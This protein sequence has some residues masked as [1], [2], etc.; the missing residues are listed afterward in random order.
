MFYLL[1][2]HFIH[3][4]MFTGNKWR[5]SSLLCLLAVGGPIPSTEDTLTGPF[6]CVLPGPRTWPPDAEG[7]YRGVSP[8]AQGM[9]KSLFCRPTPVPVGINWSSWHRGLGGWVGGGGARHSLVT[10]H[11]Q[12]PNESNE[13]LVWSRGTVTELWKSCVRFLK[14]IVTLQPLTDSYKTHSGH[15]RL[16]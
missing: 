15:R 14:P 6:F 8:L 7:T 4:E 3:K 5:N 1:I 11:T 9:I 2:R 12:A 10:W 13:L 16:I